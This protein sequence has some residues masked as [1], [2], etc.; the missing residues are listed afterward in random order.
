MGLNDTPSGERVHIGFFGRRNAGKSSLV[1]AVTGQELAVVS[2]TRGTTTDPVS[3]AMELLPVGPV[4]IIDT[5]GF[6]DEGALGEL[7]VRKT[8]QVL[9]RT[10]VAVLVADSTEG[11]K[12][13]DR[14]LIALFRQKEIPYLIAWNK[15]DLLTEIPEESA[16]E[17]YVSATERIHIEELKEK[18]ARL[19]KT[20]ENKLMLVG[21]L[22]HPGDL[23]VL[24]IPIDK[25]APKG[26]L[27]L[28]QQQVIRDILEAEAAAVCVK[29]YELRETLDKFREPPALVITDSQV[30]AKVSADVPPEIPLTSFSILMARYKGLLDMAVRG[31]AAVEKLQDGDTVLIAEGCTHHRQCDDIGSVKIPR[32]LKNYTGKK[33]NIELCSG[34]EFPDDLSKYALIIHCGGCMLNEREVRYRMKC[35]ADQQVPITNYGIAIAYMQGILKRSIGIFPHLLLEFEE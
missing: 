9:N 7:R 20:E 29:E 8:R 12:E 14:E 26:R 30:F 13:C 11:L 34:R 15:S 35:A 10:D 16:S 32:W 6:D 4:V 28:P 24:V 2:Q 23:V 22:I 33:L 17:I 1:N 3:K 21:D 27:I 19:G 25:A 18:I 5:P 31:V